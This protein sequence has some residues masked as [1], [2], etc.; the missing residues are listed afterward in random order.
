MKGN[1][2]ISLSES[3]LIEI[4][5]KWLDDKTDFNAEVTAVKADGYPYTR[6]EIKL[7]AREEPG[8]TG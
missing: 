7:S 3:A 8:A 4:V 1:N 5:Q 6:F 2:E